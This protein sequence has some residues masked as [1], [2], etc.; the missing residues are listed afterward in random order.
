MA[1]Y[2]FLLAPYV[3]MSLCVVS[4]FL[5]LALAFDSGSII[6]ATHSKAFS[7]FMH[8][9]AQLKSRVAISLGLLSVIMAFWAGTML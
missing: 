1:Y 2:F 7:A 6:T 8:R 9:R 5:S 3:V 4:V